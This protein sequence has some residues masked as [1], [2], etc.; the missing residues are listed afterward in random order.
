MSGCPFSGNSVEYTLKKLSMEDNEEDRAQTGVNRASKGGLIYGNYLQLEK[1]LNAQELQSEIK[2]NK[3]H[4]EHLFIITHQAYELWFKQILWE[5]DSVREIFQNGHVR[6]ERNMLKVIARMHRVVVIFK[7]LVQQFSVLETMTA[8]DFNDFREYLSPASGFQSLQFRLLENKIGVLQSLRVPY[9]RKHYR[10][11]FGEDYNALLLKSEQEQT[12][13]QLV[14]AWLE[15]TPGL[16]PHG[17]NFWGKFEENILKGLEEEF[18]RIQAKKD[19]EE[20]EEQMAE[21]RK[22]KEVLL[23]LFDEKRHDYLLSKG[24]RRLSYRALQGALMIYF[25]RE[26][27]R[28][29]VPF[30]LLTSLM[31]IDTLMTKWRYN[32]VCMVHR[33]LGT[34]AGTGGS[35]GYHYLRSTVSDRYKVFVDL[36][37]LSTYLVPRHWIPKMNPI[38]HKFLYTAEYSDSSYFSSDESD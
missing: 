18:L 5:L 25:Y 34:K 15:R 38:I 12:L 23:C 10:D 17:F 8:L 2:G 27:P 29:Q 21:F 3:I 9:N 19:S 1:I 16:E 22:Q 4:D 31:D 20:K 37:N 7:L 33:M 28:F 6:D 32:H 36:F 13:L 11:N 35:S 24:E 30:Q 26:E 14:E